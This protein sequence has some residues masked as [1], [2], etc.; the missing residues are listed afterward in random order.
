MLDQSTLGAL[1]KLAARGLLE[2][3]DADVLIPAAG[4]LNNLTEVLRLCLDGKFEPD[5]APDGLKDLL[6]RAGETPDFPRLEASLRQALSDVKERF[7]RIV[8]A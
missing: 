1:R 3:A 8:T 7:D 4:L 6:A 2:P 5:K